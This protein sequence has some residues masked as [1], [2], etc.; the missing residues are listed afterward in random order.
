MNLITQK[1]EGTKRP[2]V[3][4]TGTWKKSKAQWSPQKYTI[5]EDD[6]EMIARMVQDCLTKD[7]DHAAHHKDKLQKEVAEMGNSWRNLEK[8]RL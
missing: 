1:P 5:I 8:A 6:G 4:E 7:F 3:Q 2:I